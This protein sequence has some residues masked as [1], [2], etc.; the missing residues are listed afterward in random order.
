MGLIGL[1]HGVTWNFL[2]WGIW[3]G[4]GLFVHNRW[5]DWTRP[6][7]AELSGPAARL[8]PL[9]GWALTLVFVSLGWVWFALPSLSQALHVFATLFGFS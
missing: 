9:A 2:V 5:A 1:W 3:H 7:L 4:L 8:L 6:H